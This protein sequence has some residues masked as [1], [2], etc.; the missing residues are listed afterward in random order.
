MISV[1]DGWK[2]LD[3][4]AR[5]VDL[6]LRAGMY[7]VGEIKEWCGTIFLEDRPAGEPR[8]DPV[9]LVE[10]LDILIRN[11]VY[12]PEEARKIFNLYYILS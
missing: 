9:E 5:L 10:F 1:N 12:K 4:A 8:P 11:G 6:L 3:K 2:N 7:S